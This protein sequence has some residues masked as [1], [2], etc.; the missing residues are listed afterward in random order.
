[1]S[2]LSR[3]ELPLTERKRC[4]VI[5]AAVIE[6]QRDGF[7]G[8]SMNRI[9]ATAGVSKRTVYKHFASKEE[10]F[11]AIIEILLER[12]DALDEVVYDSSVPLVEQLEKIGRGMAR[13]MMSEDFIKLARVVASRFMHSPELAASAMGG[14][15]RTK[16]ILIGWIRAA[17]ADARIVVGNPEI[18][19]RQF[20][21]L[22]Q[23]F[24]FWPQL[25]GSEPALS[26]RDLNRVARS[27]AQMFVAGYSA[28]ESK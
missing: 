27:A 25:I 1:M 11:E 5:E 23:E 12:L 14:G 4:A 17:K 28:E 24:A 6:F 9:A 19:A 10:L 15:K 2:T 7:D 20:A 3:S 13:L 26:T 21:G 18:A 22:I 8:A 16:A